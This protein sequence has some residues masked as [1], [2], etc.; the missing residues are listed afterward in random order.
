MPHLS[1][2]RERER[3]YSD[4][5]SGVNYDSRYAVLRQQH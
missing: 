1:G 4:V 5:A 3:D 2:E